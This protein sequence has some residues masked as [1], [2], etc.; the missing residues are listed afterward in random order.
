MNEHCLT[1]SVAREYSS[2]ISQACNHFVYIGSLFIDHKCLLHF[3]DI[4]SLFFI[5]HPMERAYRL[6]SNSKHSSGVYSVLLDKVLE[7]VVSNI[8]E[9]EYS[10]DMSSVPYRVFR[11]FYNYALECCTHCTCL[12]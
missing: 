10:M 11:K 2:I 12:V 1:I 6:V 7:E 9:D 4:G 5:G 3:M 8:Q